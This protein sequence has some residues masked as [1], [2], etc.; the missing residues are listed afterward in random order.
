MNAVR[1]ITNHQRTTKKSRPEA[2]KQ[3]PLQMRALERPKQIQAINVGDVQ[4]LTHKQQDDLPQRD[5]KSKL[6]RQM[7]ALQKIGERLVSLPA[8]QLAKIPLDPI[9]AQAIAEARLINSREGKR[10]QLQYI[11]RLMRNVELEPIQATLDK[12]ELKSRHGKAQFH[13]IE[14]WRDKLIAEDDQALQEFLKQY[15]QTD[16]QELRQLIRNAKKATKGA[17]TELFR[18]L[19]NLID[20]A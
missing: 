12:L 4:I 7:T 18:Y 10:R 9:L 2:Q 16:R 17:D 19:R 3:H 20:L 1:N 15:P 8:A 14:R 13:Q 5:S 11:G 6:K